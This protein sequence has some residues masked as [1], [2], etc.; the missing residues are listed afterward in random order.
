[1][2][3]HSLSGQKL[4]REQM[5]QATQKRGKQGME[6]ENK[7][8]KK[9]SRKGKEVEVGFQGAACRDGQAPAVVNSCCPG[10]P[11]KETVALSSAISSGTRRATSRTMA[12]G[13]GLE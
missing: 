10:G 11:A 2:L 8:G 3:K 4:G 12:G 7:A 13:T 1:M 9:E 6:K 5:S